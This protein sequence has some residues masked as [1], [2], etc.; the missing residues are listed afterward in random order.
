MIRG[1]LLPGLLVLVGVLLAACGA[2]PTTPTSPVATATE[3]PPRAELVVGCISIQAAECRFVAEQV[4]SSVPAGRGGP[5][6]VE[7]ILGGCE[8]QGA[9]CPPSLAVREGRAVVE[10]LD[11]GEPIELSLVGPPQAPRMVVQDGF[12]SDVVRPTSPR[13]GGPGPFPFELGHCGLSHVV[14]FDGSFWI[15]IGQVDGEAPG[16]I[17]SEQGQIRL[18][19]PDR[20]Q[21]QGA[22]GFAVNLARFP[23]PKRFWLCD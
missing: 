2:P 16:W 13:V 10:Y 18:V 8:Q 19:G 4:V 23:G 22:N 9:P 14:D 21:Y 1:R 5:F 7:I 12:Y 20:V 15:P 3:A 6:A 11:G 17:N